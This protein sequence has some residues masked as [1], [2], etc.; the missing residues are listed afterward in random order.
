MHTE[1]LIF[2][3]DPKNSHVS[4]SL[5]QSVNGLLTHVHVT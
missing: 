5:L 1:D 4:S 2:A 3:F